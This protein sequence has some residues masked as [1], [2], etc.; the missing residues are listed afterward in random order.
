MDSLGLEALMAMDSWGLDLV[1]LNGDGVGLRG[2]LDS[3]GPYWRCVGDLGWDA[4]RETGCWAHCA[5]DLHVAWLGGRYGGAERWRGGLVLG[6]VR[7]M[8]FVSW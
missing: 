2:A 8:A 1:G 5:G 7:V 4:W 6:W 3:R